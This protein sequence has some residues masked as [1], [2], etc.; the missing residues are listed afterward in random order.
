MV[1]IPTIAEIRDQ[2]LDDIESANTSKTLLP[3]A[4][5]RILAT[6][7]AGVQ[8]LAYKLGLWVYNQIF[9]LTMDEAALLLR[10][11]EYGIVRTPATIWKGTGTATGTD[12]TI[13]ADGKI[14]TYNN[15][16]YEIITG[17]TISGGVA[18]VTLKSLTSGDDLNRAISDELNWSTP[19]TGLVSVLT[20]ASTTQ[21]AE[22]QESIA[23]LRI[24]LLNR[25]RNQPQG[26]AYADFIGWALEVAGIAEAFV[27]RPSPGFV[28]VYPLTD[29]ALPADRIP[30]GAK[31]TEVED[32][33]NDDHTYPFGRP[34]NA[35]AMTELVFNVELSNLSPDSAG[36]RVLIE[37]AI[38]DY[39]YSRRPQQYTDDPDPINEVSAGEIVG[40]AIAAGAKQIT[41]V[42]KNAGGSDISDTG[43]ELTISELAEPGTKTWV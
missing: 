13:I 12:G 35:L 17:G 32:Q 2:I 22:D 7:L 6:A 41:V 27:D 31:L 20:I 33:K 11:S 23:D 26:G 1:T 8:Y 34:V 38:D 40:K 4:V 30:S 24:R 19:Q 42:L 10:T 39:L 29:E 43:Y 9:T 28:N 3:K 5:W 37:T 18:T 25:Q 21:E 36:L 15:F 16:A 14:L